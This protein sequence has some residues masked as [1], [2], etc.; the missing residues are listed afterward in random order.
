M[1]AGVLAGMLAGVLAR[2]L[3]GVHVQERAC[4]QACVD[5]DLRWQTNFEPEFRYIM[6]MAAET[7]PRTDKLLLSF[8][9]PWH[10]LK[11]EFRYIMPC[12]AGVA[13]LS[14][15][16]PLYANQAVLVGR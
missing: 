13:K 12:S 1:L 16:F 7:D 8:S 6:S 14:C 2:V 9:K 11:P 5:C 10:T 15:S 4:V 3:A